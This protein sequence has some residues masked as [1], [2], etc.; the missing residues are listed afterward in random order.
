MAELTNACI[1][2]ISIPLPSSADDH[3]LKNAIFYKKRNFG[4]LVEEKD[5]NDKLLD[6]IKDIY[7]NRV[8]LNQIIQS[9][10]QFSDKNVYKHI[11]L[12][13]EKI[14]DEKN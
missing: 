8:V 13:L 2:F 4:I 9:Q 5:L 14:I 3:Q 6:I 10:S 12:I 11:N 1:P 7:K